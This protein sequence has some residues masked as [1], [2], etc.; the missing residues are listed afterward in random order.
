[1]QQQGDDFQCQGNCLFHKARTTASQLGQSSLALM[2]LARA[3]AKIEG[4]PTMVL[5]KALSTAAQG[6]GP[7][8]RIISFLRVLYAL[9]SVNSVSEKVSDKAFKLV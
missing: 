7:K 9:F 1:M 2:S 3:L 4:F 8:I 6:F 5:A